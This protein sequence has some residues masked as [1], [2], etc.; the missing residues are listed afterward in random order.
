M[1]ALRVLVI[2][3]SIFAQEKIARE[4]VAR[5]PRGSLVERAT[6]IEDTASKVELFRPNIVALN[7]SMAL[8]HIKDELLINYLIGHCALPVIAFGKV[9]ASKA[10][11]T[12]MGAIDYLL[13]PNDPAGLERF[14]AHMA[15]LVQKSVG[16]GSSAPG[17]GMGSGEVVTRE[18]WRASKPV[19]APSASRLGAARPHSPAINRR[20]VHAT[21]SGPA[22][23]HPAPPPPHRGGPVELI[24]IGSSTGGTEALSVVLHS[25]RPPL[26]PIV[27]V[28]HIPAMFS[29]LLAKRLDEECMLS[30]K[31]GASGDIVQRDHVYIAPGGK[32]M[33]VS[34]MGGKLTLDCSPGPPV[35]SCCPSVDVLFDTVANHVGDK[36]L[37]VI[38]TGM[39]RDGADGLTHMREMGAYTFG[40]DE[41]SCVV[42]GMPKAAFEQGAICEQLPL[43]HI[44]AAITRVAR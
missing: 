36:A 27:I 38:L 40:Q 12:R 4:L 13:K 32:H 37:G 31:E 30:I 14:Y 28:Q 7:F 22:T 39:G 20:P 25:L 29:R 17:D 35:H 44:A 24:A 8:L 15:E 26:P 19:V 3:N 2:D 34:R 23:V 16:T 41:A 11:A 5:L 43:S 10:A 18:I 21:D 42:Y 6:D 33:T 1:P 9:Q